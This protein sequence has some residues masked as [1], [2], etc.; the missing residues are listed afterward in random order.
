MKKL[1]PHYFNENHSNKRGIKAGWYAVE[2]DGKIVSGPF[3]SRWDCLKYIAP[4][5]TGAY[6]AHASVRT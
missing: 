2:K 1:A 6:D 3:F 5:A 4:V